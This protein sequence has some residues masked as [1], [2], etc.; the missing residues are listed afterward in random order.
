LG[1][2]ED[3]KMLV[4]TNSEQREHIINSSKCYAAR[5]FLCSE[6]VLLAVS[7]WLNIESELIPRIATGFGA[8]VG[9]YGSLCGALSG[10]I[11]SLGLKLGRDYPEKGKQKAYWFARELIEKFETE[12]GYTTC[13]EL[14]ECDL[15]TEAGH[16]KYSRLRLWD[17]KC[18]HYIESVTAI[19]YD[20]LSKHRK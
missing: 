16:R 19:V 10:G 1:N 13:R 4:K 7:E 9:G 17:V 18:V 6:S 14:T 8:G 3:G 15:T 2:L 20:M 5:G 11:I 12:F